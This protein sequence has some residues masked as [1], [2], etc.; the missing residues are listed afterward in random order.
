M[1]LELSQEITG[2]QPASFV[3]NN[4]ETNLN[5]EL[6]PE[7]TAPGGIK[8]FVKGMFLLGILADVSLPFGDGFNKIFQ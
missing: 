5:L 2:E 4:L 7:V 1:K 8:D 6:P 3:N